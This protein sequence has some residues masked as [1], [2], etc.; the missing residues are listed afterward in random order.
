MRAFLRIFLIALGGFILAPSM[1]YAQDVSKGCDAAFMNVINASA[2]LQAQREVNQASN[3]LLKPD[4]VLEYTCFK[5]VTD[6]FAG[7]AV[8]A[9]DAAGATE[10]LASNVSEAY[11]GSQFGHKFLGDRSDDSSNCIQMNA[12]WQ[13]AKCRN[14]E[15]QENDG[16]FRLFEQEGDNVSIPY[17]EDDKRK[18]LGSC[19][20]AE[21]WGELVELLTQDAEGVFGDD[22]EIQ[23]SGNSLTSRELT[24]QADLYKDANCAGVEAVKTGVKFRSG[25]EWVDEKICPMPGCYFD[26]NRCADS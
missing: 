3:L 25:G 21:N 7:S 20:P 6:A 11:I 8:F 24:I 9:E 14:F 17:N 19:D 23:S 26:G 10:A 1:A 5:D 2:E 18:F 22:L 4:S 13:L 16:F 15:E 12:V